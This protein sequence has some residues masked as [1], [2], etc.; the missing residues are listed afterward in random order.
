V[1]KKLYCMACRRWR[2]SGLTFSASAHLRA[3][4]GR[5]WARNRIDGA[6][7]LFFGIHGH[8]QQQW[9]KETRSKNERTT[10]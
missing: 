9:Q 10:P 8:C 5:P 1:L 7:L 3:M 6:W 2:R 4:E